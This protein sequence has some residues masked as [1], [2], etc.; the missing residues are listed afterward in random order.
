MAATNCPLL[1]GVPV[2]FISGIS[3]AARHGITVKSAAALEKASQL[4][5]VI[6][7]KTGTLTEGFPGVSAFF[8]VSQNSSDKADG[9]VDR[10]AVLAA[11]GALEAKSGHILGE[12]VVRYV[13]GEL[14]K[15]HLPGG[16]VTRVGLQH[17]VAVEVENGYGVTGMLAGGVRVTVGSLALIRER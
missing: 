8:L 12:A 13:R 7:D 5:A 14:E 15:A 2:A 9:V 3:V 11:A 6:L 10:H 16:G 4:N 1:I 17:V